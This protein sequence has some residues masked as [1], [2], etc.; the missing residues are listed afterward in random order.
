M[1]RAALAVAAC[2][3]CAGAARAAESAPE[4]AWGEPTTSRLPGEVSD[5]GDRHD[6]DGVYGRFDGRYALGLNAGTDLGEGGAAFAARATAHYFYMAGIYAGY[7]DG[8]GNDAL[9][10]TRGVSFGVDLR[11]TFLPRWSNG[12][13]RGPSILDLAIDSISIAMGA[14]FRSP[15]GGDFGDV[16]GFEL[17]LGFGLPLAGSMEGPWLGTRGLLRWDD[18][19]G[20]HSHTAEATASL[21]LGYQWITGP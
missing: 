12:M 17:S 4:P 6:G 11:P 2:L 10:W 9:P 18:P 13:Q 21:T 7:A 5:G 3:S 15:R 19:L 8:F 1:T 14:Y 16:R 20:G